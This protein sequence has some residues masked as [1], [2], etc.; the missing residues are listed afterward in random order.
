M[1]LD[2]KNSTHGGSFYYFCSIFIK[3]K[4]NIDMTI[5]I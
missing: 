2:G 1:R 5:K 4:K 3:F